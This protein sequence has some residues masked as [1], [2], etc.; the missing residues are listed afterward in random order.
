[1]T[2]IRTISI[3][4]LKG[5]FDSQRGQ[6]PSLVALG[7]V[8]FLGIAGVTADVG[9]AYVV[10][11]HLQSSANAAALSAVGSAY[12]IS[13]ADGAGTVAHRYA[14]SSG[15]LNASFSLGTVTVTVTAK[16]LNL[17][18][19]DKMGCPAAA[20]NA[21]QVKETVSVPTHTMQLFGVKTLTVG[22]TATAGVSQN[23]TNPWLVP[24]GAS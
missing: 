10:R 4:L 3:S 21:V 9:R 2:R 17:L 11:R 23:V 1:M 6:I 18:M 24:N 16:C 22:A 8:V 13:S 12:N 15:N 14:A 19:P 5:A 20:A 7:T